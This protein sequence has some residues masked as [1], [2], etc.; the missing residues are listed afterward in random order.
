MRL[1]ITWSL[2]LF[3]AATIGKLVVDAVVEGPSPPELAAE[4]AA[5]D[6]ADAL[7]VWFLH[8]DVRCWNCNTIEKLTHQTLTERFA[9]E[10]AS[11]TIQWR[12]TNMD[13]PGN[14]HYGEEYGLLTSSVVLGEEEG[15]GVGNWKNLSRVWD[16][17][18]DEVEFE[19]Y[20]EEA[21][22]DYLEKA[23]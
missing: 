23:R 20:V 2:L 19:D 6:S 10:L 8:T 7:V 15:D 9:G 13:E 5:P 11:G 18:T 22:R 17:V 12:V 16:L 1:A 21:I 4:V 14:E 3:V